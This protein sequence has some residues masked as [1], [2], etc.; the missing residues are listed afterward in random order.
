LR[1]LTQDIER[2]RKRLSVLEEQSSLRRGHC[3][4]TLA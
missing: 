3:C 2:S 4:G 1:R